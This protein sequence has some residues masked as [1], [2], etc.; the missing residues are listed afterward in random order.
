[1]PYYLE[2]DDRELLDKLKRQNVCAECGAELYSYYDID[3]HLPYLVCSKVI[4]HQGIAREYHEPIEL[5]IPTRRKVMEKEYGKE[6]STALEKYQGVTSLSKPEAREVLLTLWPEADQASPAEFFKAMMLCTQ[7]GLNPL[8]RHLFLIPFWNSDKK[9][10][11]HVCVQGI[12]SNRLI[13]SRKHHWTFLDDTPRIGSEAEEIKH[14][15]KVNPAMLRAIAKMRDVDTGAEVTAWGEWPL[16][17]KDRQGN[18]VDNDPKG[19]DKGNS[20]LNMTCIRAERKGLDMLYPAD[21]PPIE[22]PVADEHFIEGEYQDL[23]EDSDNNRN[24]PEDTNTKEKHKSQAKTA[25]ADPE[26]KPEKQPEKQPEAPG[27]QPPDAPGEQ[28]EGT[29]FAID[30]VWLKESLE[31]LNWTTC[32]KWLNDKYHL[33]GKRVSEIVKSLTTEQQREFAQEVEDRLQMV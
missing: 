9:R 19:I 29:A 2:T 4:G 7:Y 26:P 20:M 14:Y 25:V 16:K 11:E 10:Y 13:A 24:L 21:M 1:M 30:N 15:G 33:N 5:N 3:K 32:V 8:M 28:A 17:K 31:K 6:T 12:T 18:L 27:E 23:P 22:I